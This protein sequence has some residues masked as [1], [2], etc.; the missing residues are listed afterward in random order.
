MITLPLVMTDALEKRPGRRF[1][2]AEHLLGYA[3][4]FLELGRGDSGLP[5]E[6]CR[7]YVHVTF[8][9]F[10]IGRSRCCCCFLR[11]PERAIGRT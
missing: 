5:L 3:T 8:L 9:A 4:R 1:T 7:D 10:P 6:Y 2:P 11:E